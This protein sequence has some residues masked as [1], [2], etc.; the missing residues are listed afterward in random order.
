MSGKYKYIVFDLDG[1]LLDTLDDLRDCLN[2]ALSLHGFPTRTKEEVRRFVGNGIRKLVARAVPSGTDNPDFEACFADFKV[3]YSRGCHE[4]TKPYDGVVELMRHLREHGI[5]IAVASNKVDSAVRE[6]I[7]RYFGDLADAA[8]G[9]GATAAD[10]TVT[11]RKPEPDVVFEAMRRMGADPEK[12][13]FC[14]LYVGDSDVD[15]MTARNAG[16]DCAT[17]LWGF[18]DREE[19]IA[20]G[21]TVFASDV[22]ELERLIIEG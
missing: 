9:D 21:A 11:R 22:C 10:G 18:R 4:K 8:L 3:I 15:V 6:L 12:D 13:G 20:A 7:P 5:R 14:T 1:T 17:V 19:L 16:I 2:G